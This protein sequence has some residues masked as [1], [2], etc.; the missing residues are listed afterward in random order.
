[1]FWVA[2][3]IIAATLG[4]LFFAGDSG[5][6]GLSG[7]EVAALVSLTLIGTLV[8]SGFVSGRLR[9]GSMVRQAMVWIGILVGL[10]AA[11]EYRYELQDVA[12]RVTAGIIPGSPISVAGRDGAVTVELRRNGN[13]FRTRAQINGE[14]GSFIVDTGASTVVLTYDTAQQI[15][16]AIDQL[17][18]DIPV[19]TANGVTQAARTEVASLR[20]GDI[21]RTGIIALVAADGTLFENLLGLSFLDTLSGYDVRGDRLIL[22]D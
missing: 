22:R 3:L 16:V 14:P 12:S 20:I 19:S 18:F 1:M 2:I 15:G 7:D 9:F 11:Y 17:R 8:A 6:I 5:A 4:F 21:E 10:V 13:S